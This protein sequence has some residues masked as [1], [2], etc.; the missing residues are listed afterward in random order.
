MPEAA[1]LLLAIDYGLKRIGIATGNALTRTASPVT[2]LA[3][4]GEP[5]WPEIDALIAE[6]QPDLIVVGHPGPDADASLVS[7]LDDFITVLTNRYGVAVESVDESF[8]STAA[9]E[10]LRADR[11]EGIYN[12]RLSREKIDQRAACMIAEQWMNQALE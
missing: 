10:S 1:R 6:W 12:R 9:A 7:A 11:R 5:P 3:A 2:T 8:T 4:N